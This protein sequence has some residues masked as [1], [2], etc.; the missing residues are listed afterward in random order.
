[1]VGKKRYDR[2]APGKCENCGALGS[3]ETVDSIVYV[4]PQPRITAR[5][6]SIRARIKVTY[7]CVSCEHTTSKVISPL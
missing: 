3:Y 7:R 4:N 2:Y 6:P 1:M 5:I